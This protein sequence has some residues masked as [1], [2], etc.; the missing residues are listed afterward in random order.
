MAA[1]LFTLPIV[2]VLD[3]AGDPVSGAK[4]QFYEAGT[5]TPLDTYSDEDLL[6]ANTNPVVAN[7]AGR[8]GPIYVTPGV[9]YR[10]IVKTSADVTIYDQDEVTGSSLDELAL[11]TNGKGASLVGIEDAAGNFNAAN[12][13]AALAEIMSLLASVSNGEGASLVGIED[14]AGNFTAT[15]VEAAL[16]ELPTKE[17]GTFDV[18]LTGFAAAPAAVT[19]SYDRSGDLVCIN[20]GTARNGT[21]NATSMLS[22]VGEVPASLRP[23][24]IVYGVCSVQDNSSYAM[25][26]VSVSSA[27]TMQWWPDAASGNFTASGTKGI[28]NFTFA[29]NL[30]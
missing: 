18:N 15:D 23:S 9:A 17:T 3:T 27:G 26:I 11:I 24:G 2:T 1:P 25:G 28:T 6:T 20:S 7:A 10:V 29:Y 12:V 21:S 5:T 30:N 14:S 19:F 8:A 4:L 16:A 13:E 22:G